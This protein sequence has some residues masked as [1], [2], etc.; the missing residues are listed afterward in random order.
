MTLSGRGYAY[1]PAKAK[2]LLAEAGYPDG[3]GFPVV[4]LWSSAK[5]ESTKAELAAYQR[6]LAEVGGAGGHPFCTRLADL[7]SDAGAGKAPH[8]PPGV[9]CG[10]P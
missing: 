8:V 10:Y 3:A 6:Y 9:V 4:Q 2:R 5:A 7:L 1:D